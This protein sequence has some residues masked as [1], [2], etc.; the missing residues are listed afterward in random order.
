MRRLLVAGAAVV[1]A[2]ILGLSARRT[3]SSPANAQGQGCATQPAIVCIAITVTPGFSATPTA[4]ATAVPS[5]TSTASP[6]ATATEVIDPT[7]TQIVQGTIGPTEPVRLGIYGPHSQQRVR[8]CPK[9]SDV[10]CP[11]VAWIGGGSYWAVW[12]ENRNTPGQIWLRIEDRARNISG[13]VALV[14]NDYFYGVYTPDN[15]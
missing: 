14:I 8:A 9:F 13:W 1:L 4:S 5:A 10:E 6:T 15:Q 2:G 7:P 3:P 12:A 11:R